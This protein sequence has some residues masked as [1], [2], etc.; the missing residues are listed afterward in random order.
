MSDTLKS[1]FAADRLKR[2]LIEKIKSGAL[3]AGS[4][5][6]SERKLAVEYS[7]SYLTARKAVTQIGRASCRERV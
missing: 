3:S 7:I 4:R 2:D 5:L 6:I 1:G